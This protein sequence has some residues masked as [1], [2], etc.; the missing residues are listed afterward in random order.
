VQPALFFP[1]SATCGLLFLL[2]LRLLFLLSLLFLLGATCTRFAVSTAPLFLG[3]TGKGK[4]CPSQQAG[5]T[6]P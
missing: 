1:A 2:L 6:E 3:A 5:D 4:A